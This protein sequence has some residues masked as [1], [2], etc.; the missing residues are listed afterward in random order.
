[1]ISYAQNGED[2]VLMRLFADVSSGFYVDVG[3][4]DP[5]VDSVTKVFYDS[6]WSGI[7]VEPNPARVADLDR[8]RH[9]DRNVCAAA[10]DRSGT[11]ELLVTR[12]W[13]L[14]TVDPSIIDASNADYAIVARVET[15]MMPLE[16]IIAEHV[17]GRTIHFLKIDVEGHEAAV[18]RGV[19]WSRHRPLVLVIEASCPTTGA[20]TWA[21]WEPCLASAGYSFALFD[22]LNRFYVCNERADLLP[23]LSHGACCLDGYITAREAELRTRLRMTSPAGPPTTRIAALEKC[24]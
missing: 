9:R 7:N 2:V 8:V 17:N 21:G 24:K 11:I 13:P 5:E 20:P 10:S 23:K 12:Y 22:G 1:M 18:L 19:D 16:S 15:P 4:G 6:G 3:A 14:A